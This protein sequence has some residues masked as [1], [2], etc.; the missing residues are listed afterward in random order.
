MFDRN[1]LSW[2]MKKMLLHMPC[3]I[4]YY[5]SDMY[6]YGNNNQISLLL[7]WGN[8][9]CVLL[10]RY[11]MMSVMVSVVYDITMCK[12]TSLWSCKLSTYDQTCFPWCIVV[13]LRCV[14]FVPVLFV[15]EVNKPLQCFFLFFFS[16]QIH[17]SAFWVQQHLDL[18]FS[19]PLRGSRDLLF[20]T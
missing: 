5:I 14:V 18:L 20:L 1:M 17:N 2:S 13:M 12:F 15:D 6:S 7:S 19:Y 8:L 4:M 16:Y 10:I 11:M 3:L 9:L